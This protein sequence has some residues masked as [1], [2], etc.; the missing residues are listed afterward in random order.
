MQLWV[1]GEYKK[2]A[3]SQADMDSYFNRAPTT[4]AFHKK[5][6]PV[7]PLP[8]KEVEATPGPGAY[9][10]TETTRMGQ[11]LNWESAPQT[12]QSSFKAA[13]HK[14]ILLGNPESPAPTKYSMADPW[15][16]K[17]GLSRA[18]SHSPSRAGTSSFGGRSGTTSLN[19]MSSIIFL[20]DP[21]EASKPPSGPG[22]GSYELQYFQGIKSTLDKSAGKTS[23]NF[24]PPEFT[25][26]FGA[27]LSK[28]PEDATTGDYTLSGQGEGGPK[29]LGS[30]PKGVGAPFKS[31]VPGR[32]EYDLKESAK[33]PGPAYYTPKL[34]AKKTSHHLNARKYMVV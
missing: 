14:L 19:Q 7:K 3:P 23:A 24:Q 32:A 28:V 33:A 31:Q 11:N 2:Q 17:S 15:D 18:A 27:P 9:S 21:K 8:P 34:P 10:C 29:R 30:P 6:T 25:D 12:Y 5:V 16:P 13:P 20:E 1:P 4:A 22:P 26:R